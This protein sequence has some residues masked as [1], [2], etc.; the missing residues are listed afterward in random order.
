MSLSFRFL[1]PATATQ[2][3]APQSLICRTGFG[4]PQV[5]L[6]AQ[7]QRLHLIASITAGQSLDRLFLFGTNE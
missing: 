1:G 6:D 2:Q 4:Y 5:E 7:L 3:L